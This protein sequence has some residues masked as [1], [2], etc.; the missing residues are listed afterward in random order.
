MEWIVKVLD[1]GHITA[2]KSALTPLLDEGLTLDIPYFGF[3]LQKDGR[4]ILVHW[5][6]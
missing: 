5:D 3:L 4:N 2:P 1:Y 6:F